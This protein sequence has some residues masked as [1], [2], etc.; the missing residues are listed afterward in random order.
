M[1]GRGHS[2]PAGNQHLSWRLRRDHRLKTRGDLPPTPI[3]AELPRSVA[4]R[5]RGDQGPQSDPRCVWRTGGV[6]HLSSKTGPSPRLPQAPR[7]RFQ[8]SGAQVPRAGQKAAVTALGTDLGT[9]L[10]RAGDE[11][12]QQQQQESAG[13][14]GPHLAGP[15]L[16]A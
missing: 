3:P 10:R 12:Q 14:A 8:W 5:L 11:Q 6:W 13:A 9:E 16:S 15:D 2:D 4:R 1:E 7:P